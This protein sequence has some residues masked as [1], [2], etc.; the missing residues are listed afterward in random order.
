MERPEA[1]ALVAA[2]ALSLVHLSARRLRF[3]DEIPRSRWLSAAGGI[4]VAYVFV[5]ILPA[6]NEAQ[7]AVGRAAGT[8]LAFVEHHVYVVALV[9]L[10]VFYG[11]ERLAAISR[12]RRR[13]RGEEDAATGAI[14]WLSM[15]SFA[16]YNGVIGYLLVERSHAGLGGLALFALAMAVHFV[17]SDK[18]LRENHK[19]AYH[20]IGRWLL[21]AAPLA[22]WATALAFDVSDAAFGILLAFLAGGIVLNVLK[23]ELPE[24]R[25]S[26]FG[27]FAAGAAAYAALL[28]AA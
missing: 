21:A 1:V 12:Q 25:A 11:I 6:L 18:G 3:V 17:V 24:E 5:H 7:E 8:G 14:F 19:S 10:A 15:S 2:V 23:E 13:E 20:A 27:A 16:A 9:G 22:G 26:R 4:S 28:I